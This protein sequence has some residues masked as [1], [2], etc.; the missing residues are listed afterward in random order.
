LNML[1]SDMRRIIAIPACGGK[2]SGSVYLL[3][4]NGL[5]IT[6]STSDRTP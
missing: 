6:S 1:A 5:W 4:N 3:V 2:P